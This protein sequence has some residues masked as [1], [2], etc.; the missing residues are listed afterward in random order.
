[1]RLQ[2]C[3]GIKERWFEQRAA[4]IFL[5]ALLFLFRPIMA[6]GFMTWAGITIFTE[7]LFVLLAAGFIL[8]RWETFLNLL[9]NTS[10]SVKICAGFL[11]ASGVI[12]WLIGGYYRPEYLGL[13]LLW[14]TIPA[15]AAVYRNDLERKLPVF[16]GIFWLFNVIICCLSES[17]IGVMFGITGNWN[18]SATLMAVSLPFALRCVPLH[19]KGRK[20]YLAVICLI[21]LFLLY[22][23]QS[24]ALVVSVA[25]TGAFWLF[26]KF[27]KFRIPMFAAAVISV[28]IAGF[29]AFR[30]FPEQTNN[31]LKREIRVE[32]WKG[33][34]N[35]IKAYPAGAGVVTFEN[36]FIPFRTEE[37][38]KNKHCSIRDDHPHNEFLY[39]AATLGVGAAAAFAFWI[40]MTLWNVVREYDSGMMS[41]K[42]VLFLL[43]FLLIFCGGMLDLSFHVWPI[44]ILG[45]LFFGMFAFPGER[46]PELLS[47]GPANRIGRTVFLFTVV[48]G[49][50]NFVGTFCWEASHLAIGRMNI[51]A[52]KRY[53]K[54]ALVLTPEIPNLVY[55][56]ANEMLSRDSEFSMEL[57]ERLQ[58][59]PWKDYAHIHGLKSMLYRQMKQY[60][61]AIQESLLDA[62]HFPLLVRPIMDVAVLYGDLGI[63]EKEAYQ[64]LNSELQSRI[65]KRNLTPAQL[66]EIY[67]NPEYDMHPE[68]IGEIV[69]PDI[70]WFFDQ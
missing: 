15:F 65:Q 3:D 31:F 6:A 14:V 35:M 66:R 16:L 7:G 25:V 24:R 33:T 4:L 37:Y 57:V 46:V 36:S 59:S 51:P 1:M 21:T 19:C 56:S 8:F 69:T 28:A 62:Q 49:I 38:F 45:L 48:L 64:R 52:A 70:K 63:R 44:G 60:E 13:S 54:T 40:F 61:N 32:I 43:C 27:R 29:F 41:R 50:V 10:W 68:R 12:H 42:R 26:L 30:V 47:E 23:L 34:L 2:L 55:R 58:Q 53:A 17:L 18:W 9:K 67:R 39:L 5:T 20:I 22:Y 11:L